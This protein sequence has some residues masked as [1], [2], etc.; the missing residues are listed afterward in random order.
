MPAPSPLGDPGADHSITGGARAPSGDC[1]RVLPRLRVQGRPH[2]YASWARTLADY[3]TWDFYKKAGFSAYPPGY[4]Y[5]LWPIGLLSKL[6][7]P[8]EPASVAIGLIKLPPIL[9]DIAV[10]A[11]LYSLVSGWARPSRRAEALG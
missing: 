5:L 10:G 9:S 2:I 11:V 3:G 8:G 1:L 4:L 7:A 6:I